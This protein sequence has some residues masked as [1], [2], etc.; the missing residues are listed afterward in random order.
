MGESIPF[1]ITQRFVTR[2]QQLMKVLCEV[3]TPIF[4]RNHRQY[5]TTAP[6]RQLGFKPDINEFKLNIVTRWRSKLT[7]HVPSKIRAAKFATP[8]LMMFSN[9]RKTV[10]SCDR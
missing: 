10:N 1:R 4:S 9:L 5:I 2:C 3:A 8:R 6:R 7:L